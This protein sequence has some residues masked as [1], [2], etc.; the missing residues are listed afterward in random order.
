[1]I[2]VIITMTG[3]SYNSADEY[4]IFDN[5]T[6]TFAD[7]ADANK[8]LAERYGKSWRQRKKMY[9]DS[10]DGEL[11]CGYIVGFPNADLSH[12]P[13]KKWLQQDWIEFCEVTP[14]LPV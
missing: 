4:R 10:K 2:Q 14:I 9:I 7:K 12:A 3:K 13:V 11:H 8:A 6:L 1:M 5:E